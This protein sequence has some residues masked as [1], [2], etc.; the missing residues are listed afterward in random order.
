[1]ATME[2]VLVPL[3]L[4]HRFQVEAAAT[5]LGGM[6]Y[7]YAMRGDGREP[8]TPVPA[9]EQAAALSALM[10]TLNPAELTIPA[11]ILDKLPPR[12]SGYGRTREL[13]P[14][15]TG[16]MFDTITPASVAAQHTIG[17]VMQNARMARVVQQHAQDSKLPGLQDILT[18]IDDA[19]FGQSSNGDYEAEVS[20]A[21][22]RVYVDKLMALASTAPMP[23]VRAI[24]SEH[25]EDL[26][27]RLTRKIRRASD[28]DRAHYKLLVAD[29]KRF[30]TRSMDAA[31]QPDAAEAPPGA[32]IGEPAMN[33]LGNQEHWWRDEAR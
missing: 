9:D 6:H 18:A 22:E 23:Q 13:F 7:I 26:A 33:W 15:Y 10:A 16:L 1:M 25:L 11:S 8:V 28:G 4:Y 30:M 17:Q 24:A 14:R 32:P 19:T 27:A 3:Y 5:A 12:P 2:E 20:R 29:I 21:I 31:K